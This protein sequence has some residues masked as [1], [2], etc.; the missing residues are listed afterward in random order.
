MQYLYLNLTEQYT[1]F[2]LCM[3]YVYHDFGIIKNE[4]EGEELG[5]SLYL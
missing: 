5:I 1:S 3:Y 4:N 2:W